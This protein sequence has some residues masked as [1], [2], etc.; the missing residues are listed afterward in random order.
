[1]ATSVLIPVTVHLFLKMINTF[2]S[3]HVM[4]TMNGGSAQRWGADV[5]ARIGSNRA[6]AAAGLQHYK[7]TSVAFRYFAEFASA[8]AKKVMQQV[9]M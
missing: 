2:F 8:A 6:A 5:Q 7:K 1:M 9:S 4:N 3:L